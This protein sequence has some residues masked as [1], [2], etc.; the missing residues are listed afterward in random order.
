[1]RILYFFMVVCLVL[2]FGCAAMKPQRDVLQDNIFYS[3]T[4]PRIKIK[5]HPDFKLDNSPQ[6]AAGYI[7]MLSSVHGK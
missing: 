5:I 2:T 3:S 6:L 1:M 7:L 4:S